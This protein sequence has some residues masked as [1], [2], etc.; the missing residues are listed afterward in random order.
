[1][2]TK[3]EGLLHNVDRN[4]SQSNYM[5]ISTQLEDAIKQNKETPLQWIALP[6]NRTKNNQ[7]EEGQTQK[8][9]QTQGHSPTTKQKPCRQQH[10]PHQHQQQRQGPWNVKQ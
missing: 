10:Q 5:R 9:K 6:G 1:M 4:Q 8:P 7:K 2:T 3:L